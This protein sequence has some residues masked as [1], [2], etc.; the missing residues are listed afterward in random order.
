LLAQGHVTS[1]KATNELWHRRK[2]SFNLVQNMGHKGP[3]LR[4]RCIGPGRDR[5]QIIFYFIL[6]YSI[7]APTTISVAR[8]IIIITTI[9][10][11]STKG[12]HRPIQSVYSLYNPLLHKTCQYKTEN[13]ISVDRK[14]R[15]SIQYNTISGISTNVS[16]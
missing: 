1:V 12:H 10:C 11:T 6:F 5:T 14:L 7:V 4:T 13:L 8:I 9:I 16:E 15:Y 3:V 2:G